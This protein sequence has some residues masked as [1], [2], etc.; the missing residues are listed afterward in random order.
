VLF[1]QADEIDKARG[2]Q[3]LREPSPA[4]QRYREYELLYRALTSA[5]KNGDE[6]WRLNPRLTR[7]SSI[8]EAKTAI[9]EDW[10]NYGF[11]REVEAAREAFLA[12]T[13]ARAWTDWMEAESAFTNG[14]VFLTPDIWVPQTILFPPASEWLSM[15]SWIRG[16][17]STGDP[18]VK[19]RFQIA[20]VQIIRPWM[21]IE[22]LLDGRIQIKRQ[23]TKGRRP[24]LSDGTAPTGL[25]YPEGMLAVIPEELILVR[26]IRFIVANS[27]PEEQAPSDLNH[28][29]GLFSYPDDVNLVGY[30]VHALPKVPQ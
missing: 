16:V 20:R 24:V 6:T 18:R 15:P 11:K 4:V 21:A 1:R 17:S 5:A 9:G 13:G 29:L 23:S 14:R 25:S 7:Y 19:V 2:V 8:E 28:P 26:G 22:A 30:V 12:H 10:V 27:T 3:Y